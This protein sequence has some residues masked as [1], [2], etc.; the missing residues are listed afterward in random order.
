LTGN[1]TWRESNRRNGLQNDTHIYCITLTWDNSAALVF[2]WPRFKAWLRLTFMVSLRS[3]WI[4]FCT[5]QSDCEKM[6][7][8]KKWHGLC[9]L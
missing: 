8:N 4:W 7:E 9:N 3:S 1:L 6:I 5:W 2:D